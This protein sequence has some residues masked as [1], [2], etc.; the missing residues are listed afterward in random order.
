M[1]TD[2]DFADIY[3]QVPPFSF[4]VPFSLFFFADCISLYLVVDVPK[5]SPPNDL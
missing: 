4:F 2:E 5:Y 3:A 1:E